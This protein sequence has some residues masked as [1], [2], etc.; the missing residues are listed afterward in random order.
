MKIL[1]LLTQDLESPSG[2][3]RYLPMALG[4]VGAGHQVEIAGLHPDY[5]QL[6]EKHKNI[7]GVD[8]HY[9]APMHVKKQNNEK[10]YYTPLQLLG[11][12]LWATWALTKVALQS[13]ADVIQVAKPHPMNGIAGLAAKYLLGKALYVDCDDYEAG[14]NRFRG[15]WQ[16]KIVGFF[17]KN[18]PQQGKFVT[19]NTNFMCQKLIS[20]GVPSEKI[21]YIPNGVDADRFL[22]LPAEQKAKIRKQLNLEGKQVV[23]YIGS[24]SL[25]SHPIDLLLRAFPKVLEQVPETHLLIVGGGE[26][27][28]VLKELSH[29]LQIQKNTIFVGRVPPQDVPLY[30]HF[31]NISIDPVYDNAAARG[32]S[33]LKL[34][35]S[36]IS[37]VPYVTA[38]VG[39]RRVLMGEPSAGILVTPGDPDALANAII[40]LL[41]DQRLSNDLQELGVKCWFGP[42]SL[43]MGDNFM[44]AIG[45]AIESYD[46][47]L[48]LLSK[49]S[50]NSD[51]VQSEVEM[52]MERERS[53]KKTILIPI[54]LDH[55]IMDTSKSWVKMITRTRHIGNFEAWQY[56]ES[57]QN[58][59]GQLVRG[60]RIDL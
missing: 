57:Y 28:P 12:I 26:D 5:H 44:D 29:H 9:V 19:A 15:S 22:S 6:T 43:K 4:L 24:L 27:L 20:W 1:F 3:G 52:V 33:P 60:M 47:V 53:E 37:G 16:Q 56:A 39:D 30:Y 59:M 34:F 58:S 40:R 36:W 14:S 42:E 45:R 35:E 55:S 2:L 17:E 25:P 7:K 13:S 18:I 41:S 8:V 38:D 10:S 54:M 11:I 51:W 48:L 49:D 21:V 50:V 31:S 32:R 23:A 46:K